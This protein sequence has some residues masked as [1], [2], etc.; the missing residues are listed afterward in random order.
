MLIAAGAQRYDFFGAIVLHI[1]FLAYLEW[2]HKHNYRKIVPSSIWIILA[3]LGI[4]LF[5]HVE[6][7]GYIFFSF[8][9][10]LKKNPK[11]SPYSAVF[12]GAQTAFIAGALIGYS[13]LTLFAFAI[14]YLR[15][16]AGDI[17][18][19]EKDR[20]EKLKT[21]PI[22]FGM[23]KGP[24]WTHLIAT[25]ITSAIW[26]SFTNLETYWLVVVFVI[27]ILSYELTAR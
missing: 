10:T 13:Y 22:L 12:R 23:K 25:M 6:V 21:L 8:L 14:L 27:Q 19:V 11:F 7:I 16:L 5:R 24:Y 1:A 4:F 17:R 18:D 26:F 3:I 20:K 2:N 15:N 9:Y